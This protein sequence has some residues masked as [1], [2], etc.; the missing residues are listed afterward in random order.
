[1]RRVIIMYVLKS[2]NGQKLA[3]GPQMYYH[4]VSISR[5]S[6]YFSALASAT[7][8]ESIACKHWRSTVYVI[9]AVK[10]KIL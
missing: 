1:M 10:C 7:R 8:S 5:V 2:L 4:I 3:N 9:G 6:T